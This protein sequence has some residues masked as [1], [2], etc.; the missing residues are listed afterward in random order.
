M[1]H[2]SLISHPLPGSGAFADYLHVRFPL[3]IPRCRLLSGEQSLSAMGAVVGGK[4]SDFSGAVSPVN[5]AL[6]TF[7]YERTF[8]RFPGGACMLRASCR[9]TCL[10]E[11][12]SA[13]KE[14]SPA[15]GEISPT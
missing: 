1:I 10:Q 9:C 3:G 14:N 2:H 4:K 5:A 12:G 15:L 6:R 11:L 13:G 7:S 8:I